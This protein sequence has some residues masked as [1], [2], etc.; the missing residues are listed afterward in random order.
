MTTNI[1]KV[2]REAVEEYN[3]ENEK[4]IEENGFIICIKRAPAGLIAQL[5]IEPN[6]VDQEVYHAWPSYHGGREIL[7]L[8]CTGR[9]SDSE[10]EAIET[11]RRSVLRKIKMIE[12]NTD[13]RPSQDRKLELLKKFIKS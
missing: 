7:F 8:D 4:L 10:E 11:L 12:K 3:K 2:V 6:L 1:R 9:W 13:R 5:Y